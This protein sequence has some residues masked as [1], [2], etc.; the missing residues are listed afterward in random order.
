VRV[1]ITN[2]FQ[3]R[4]HIRTG[5][6]DFIF[7][8]RSRKHRQ[9]SAV[10]ANTFSCASIIV[11]IVVVDVDAAGLG[12]R[13]GSGARC[14]VPCAPGHKHFLVDNNCL[15]VPSVLGLGSWS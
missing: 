9:C 4:L 6:L 13:G 8:C 3:H 15:A 1:R 14:D 7:K 10:A 5:L 12:A 2:L 11:I